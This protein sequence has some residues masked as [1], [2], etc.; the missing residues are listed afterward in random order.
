[1]SSPNSR[2][3]LSSVPSEDQPPDKDIETDIILDISAELDKDKAG[4]KSGCQ[5]IKYPIG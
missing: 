1:M 2:F 3:I 5:L 4:T